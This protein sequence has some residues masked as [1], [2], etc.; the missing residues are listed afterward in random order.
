M[1]E[2]KQIDRQLIFD[3]NHSLLEIIDGG[4]EGVVV[5]IYEK[6]TGEYT[7]FLINLEETSRMFQKLR[8]MFVMQEIAMPSK[9]HDLLTRM[10]SC[11]KRYDFQLGDKTLIRQAIEALCKIEKINKES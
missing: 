7:G 3:H 5:R 8:D 6:Q 4:A 2:D 11:N 10:Q 9:L 1:T